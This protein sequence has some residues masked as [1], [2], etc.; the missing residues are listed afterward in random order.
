ML[1]IQSI[2]NTKVKSAYLIL[3]VSERLKRDIVI[4]LKKVNTKKESMKEW[5]CDGFSD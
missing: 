5:K 3:G 4:N 2:H 1:F